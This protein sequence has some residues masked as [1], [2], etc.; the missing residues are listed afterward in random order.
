MSNKNY[1]PTNAEVLA[2]MIE[3]TASIQANFASIQRSHRFPVH[4]FIKIENMAAQAGV[5][6]ST[7]I[8]QLL[9]AGMEAVFQQ[10]DEEVINQIGTVTSEQRER[11]EKLGN[12]TKPKLVK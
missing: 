3:R 11:L 1:R 7:I 5:P 10:L 4:L 12:D 6:I 8:N 2:G 9:E